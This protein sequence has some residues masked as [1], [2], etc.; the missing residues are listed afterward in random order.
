M[1]KSLHI[2]GIVTCFALPVVLYFVFVSRYSV[3]VPVDD[4]FSDVALIGKTFS[5]HL[6]LRDLWAQHNENRI[7]FPNLIVLVLAYSTHLDVRTEE[8]LSAVLLV[9]SI[10][11]LIWTHRRRSATPLIWYCPI[12][13][14]MLSWSQFQNSLWGFQ[15]AWYV[16]LI[17]LMGSLALLD[18]DETTIFTAAAAAAVAVIGSYSSL[19]G[20]LIWPA[21]F[22][23]LLYRRQTWKFLVAWGLVAVATTGLYFYN[24]NR[25]T[26]GSPYQLNVLLHPVVAAKLLVFSLGNVLGAPGLNNRILP[27]TPAHPVLGLANPWVI[28]FGVVLLFS[29]A[30]AILTTGITKTRHRPEPLGITLIVVGLGFAGMTAIGRGV[31]G[32]LGVGQSRYVTFNMLVLVGTYLVIISRPRRDLAKRPWAPSLRLAIRDS[33]RAYSL[34]VCACVLIAIIGGYRYGLSN[35]RG[36]HSVQQLQAR[37]IRKYRSEPPIAISF[38]NP[39]FSET[40]TLHLIQVSQRDRLSLFDEP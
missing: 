24:Y 9:V 25:S 19:Q 15:L 31:D 36:Y 23:L 20:L 18:R 28:A 33:S 2:V 17:C 16:V 10:A 27:S 39:G 29:A 35:A 32:Y 37:I 7:F 22:L 34:V 6:Q 3:N 5:G 1:K 11:L 8:Y 13:V 12:V 40:L 30:I 21:G 38:V 14:L 4:Q 26:Q